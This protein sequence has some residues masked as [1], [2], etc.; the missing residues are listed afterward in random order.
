MKTSLRKS[1][2]TSRREPT[3]ALINIVFLM[4]IFF[5]I[6][7]TLAAPLEGDLKLVDTA[8]LEGAAPPDALV[9]NAEGQLSFRAE[10]ITPDAYIA[11]ASQAERATVRLVPDRAVSAA[12]LVE[13]ASALKAAGA[14]A[15]LL[16]TE[17]ALP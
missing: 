2:T 15:I 6:A 16:V 11:G 4:L 5:L 13:T 7:G 3:I 14:G 9:L 17:K 1:K 12:V 8:G 10:N